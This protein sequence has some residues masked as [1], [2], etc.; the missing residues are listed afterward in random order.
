[1]TVIDQVLAVKEEDVK[2]DLEMHD[3]TSCR[4]GDPF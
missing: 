3:L 4:R 2:T 1:M